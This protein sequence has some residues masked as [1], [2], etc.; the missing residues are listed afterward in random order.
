MMLHAVDGDGDGDG[1]DNHLP[2]CTTRCIENPKGGE[3]G[4][5]VEEGRV[6]LN[7]DGMCAADD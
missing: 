7:D 1:D 3:G 5:G 2:A 4:W 6:R